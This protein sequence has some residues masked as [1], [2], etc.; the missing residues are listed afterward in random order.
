M[1][2]RI[3]INKHVSHSN[4][5][6]LLTLF[7][8]TAASFISCTP[9]TQQAVNKEPVA[10]IDTLAPTYALAGETISFSG[11]GTDQ[12]GNIT[13]YS[14]R[15]S[16]DG[17]INTTASFS[18]TTLSAGSHTIYF[19]VQDNAGVWSPETSKAFTIASKD[20]DA[21]IINDFSISPPEIAIGSA[22]TLRWN[23][24]K[25]TI[26]TIDQGIGNVSDKGER[27]ISPAVT[28]TYTLT[29]KNSGSIVTSHVQVRVK[30][31]PTINSFTSNPSS[32]TIGGKSL[33]SWDVS[34]SLD[35]SITPDIGTVNPKG[36]ID[37]SPSATTNYILTATNALGSSS[38]ETKIRV[39][40]E[41]EIVYRLDEI[42][43]LGESGTVHQDGTI[44][45]KNLRV[46][47]DDLNKGM[48]LFYTFDISKLPNN[49]IIRSATLDLRGSTVQIRP[50]TLGKLRVY[51]D[52]FGLLD[53]SDFKINFPEGT[54]NGL[55]FTFTSLPNISFSLSQYWI[56]RLQS[57]ANAGTPRFQIRLQ[58]ER[59]TN[60]DSEWDFVRYT[61]TNPKLT[62]E[63]TK[64]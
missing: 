11:H 10:Y 42:A 31:P 46:G 3:S 16:I 38:Q 32:I 25:A 15:S 34:N 26:I 30:G 57:M 47:D 13:G 43:I 39:T 12:D 35:V 54:E 62:I 48:Q 58:F 7:L 56:N 23:I 14:W 8:F 50:F 17:V 52:Q 53:S 27:V 22:T 59:F 18:S 2:Q 37:V 60:D 1:K 44:D 36:T 63:Y 21:P 6:A 20:T 41:S 33:L 55:L 64:R 9:A 28:T 45:H 24:S 19:K 40:S 51:N 61:D 5:L 4:L 49:A 29:A